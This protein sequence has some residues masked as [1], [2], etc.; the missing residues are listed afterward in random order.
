MAA[1]ALPG[2][3][4]ERLSNSDTR[5]NYII[6]RGEAATEDEARQAIAVAG[7]VVEI[8]NAIPCLPRPLP[9]RTLRRCSTTFGSG[10]GGSR[11]NY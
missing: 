11:T 10:R 3:F 1:A 2:D 6:H 9:W 7:R 4:W 5:R 8:M